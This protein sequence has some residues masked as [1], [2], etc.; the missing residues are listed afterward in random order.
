MASVR[1]PGDAGNDG[2]KILVDGS[3][4]GIDS[5][6][7]GFDFKMYLDFPPD[8]N[9]SQVEHILE[10]A[11]IAT[12]LDVNSHMLQ[13]KRSDDIEKTLQL[14][15]FDAQSISRVKDYHENEIAEVS[16]PESFV[17]RLPLKYHASTITWKPY[18]K[19]YGVTYE[20]VRKL[21]DG[22]SADIADQRAA[23]YNIWD[24][25]GP[26]TLFMKEYV[27][28]AFLR[29]DGGRPDSLELGIYERQLKTDVAIAIKQSGRENGEILAGEFLRD[30]KKDLDA[31]LDTVL[32]GRGR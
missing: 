29:A 31:D 27:K 2:Y 30:L 23:D 17:D 1:L 5:I 13:I 20:Q 21:T 16:D 18:K 28:D 32:V 4:H 11:G 3:E 7:I 9:R 10:K 24:S 14:L 6:Q 22:V 26:L 12:S 19:K 15:G 8:G 25:E